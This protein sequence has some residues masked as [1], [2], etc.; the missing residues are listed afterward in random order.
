MKPAYKAA[1]LSAILI[2]ILGVLP[3]IAFSALGLSTVA[4]VGVLGA[5]SGFL[6]AVQAGPKF[7]ITL[8]LPLAVASA[9]ASVFTD[10]PLLGALLMLIVAGG[11]GLSAV[12]GLEGALMMAVTSLGFI[13]AD[14]PTSDKDI[15]I[16]LVI[17][18]VMLVS[19]VYGTGI[20][21]LL[22]KRLPKR[23]E[24]TCLSLD[25]ARIFGAAS[26]LLTGVATWFVLFT[27][28]EHTGAWVLLTITVVLQPFA[29][30]GVAKAIHR[31]A[32]TMLGIILVIALGELTTNKWVL[33]ALGF[34][35]MT[36][37]VTFML[38]KRP[39]WWFVAALTMAI[40]LLEGASTSI[41]DTAAHRLIATFIGTGSALAVSIA[42]VPFAK[43]DAVKRGLTKY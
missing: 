10:Q 9:L 11:R 18:A 22:Q 23:P 34:I 4:S 17:F 25:R 15:P 2:V 8:A 43:R 26:G 33:F 38:L 16:W 29:K 41:D 32:G 36:L 5:A 40:V 14:P 28:L 31:A 39:Y 3:S 37:S 7:G 20:I 27:N 24:P 13:V 21:V 19:T 1:L 35:A 30:D 6:A 42:I 12:R